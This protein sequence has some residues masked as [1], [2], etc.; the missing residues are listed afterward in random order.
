MNNIIN[1]KNIQFLLYMQSL[2][3]NKYKIF[4]FQVNINKSTISQVNVNKSNVLTIFIK[5]RA[6]LQNIKYPKKIF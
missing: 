6:L 2:I 1:I 4:F 3:F 5:G